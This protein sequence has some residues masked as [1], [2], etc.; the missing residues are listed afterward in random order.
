[1]SGDNKSDLEIK[2]RNIRNPFNNQDKGA[3]PEE[4]LFLVPNNSTEEDVFTASL[5]NLKSEDV[6]LK[7]TPTAKKKKSSG[8]TARRLILIMCTVVIIACVVYLVWSFYEK[9]RGNALYSDV[10]SQFGDVFE[11]DDGGDGAVS[12]LNS[13]KSATTILC[14]KDRLAAGANPGDNLSGND[15]KIDEM[16]AKLTS[17]SESF[18]DLYGW[19]YIGGTAIN[20]PLVQ[21]EDNDFYLNNSPYKKPLVNGSIFVDYRNNTDIMRNFNTVMYGHNLQGGGMFHDVQACFYE[22]EEM[23]QK[24]LIYIY[25]MDGAFVYEPFAVYETV[26]DYQY[27]RTEFASTDEFVKW[28][29]EMHSNT[30]YEKDMEFFASDRVLTLSTCTNRA[31]NGRYSLQAKLVNI[32]R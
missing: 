23:F 32:I 7:K 20:H 14:L 13:L 18:P 28:A 12:R 15:P 21:G 29:K 24:S 6:E 1:M 11:E 10:A 16:R 22:N 2:M 25:T 26:S 31:E 3:L 4:E 5:H 19:I 8:A 30:V 9:Y 17:L 27:F